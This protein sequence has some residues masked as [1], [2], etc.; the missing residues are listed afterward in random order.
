VKPTSSAEADLIY[1]ANNESQSLSAFH[2]IHGQMNSMNKVN[3][4]ALFQEFVNGTEFI[5]DGISRDGVYKVTAVWECDKRS[6]NG[7]HFVSYGSKLRDTRDS[8]VQALLVYAKKVIQALQIF[9]GPSHM[10]LKLGSTIE[11]VYD[12]VLIDVAACCHG[13]EGTWVTV[14]NE[15]IG[16]NQVGYISSFSI[17]YL[18]N[19]QYL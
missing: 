14:T 15:C 16:Y 7:A 4:G 19:I 6:V 17:D 5:V 11:G 13:G 1:V 8:D 18:I 3:D 10:E 12:P 9:Q 2:A